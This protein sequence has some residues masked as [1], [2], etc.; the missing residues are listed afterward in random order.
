V[1]MATYHVWEAWVTSPLGPCVI[2]R[3]K[4]RSAVEAHRLILP[5][6]G[7]MTYTLRLARK[8]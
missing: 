7:D 8:G 6:L 3:V 1:S 4:A 2:T 5:Q